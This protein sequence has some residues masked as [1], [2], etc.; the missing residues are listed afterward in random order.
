MGRSPHTVAGTVLTVPGLLLVPGFG[1]RGYRCG[2]AAGEEPRTDLINVMSKR[3]I[4]I[5]RDDIRRGQLA[6]ALSKEGAEVTG[7]DAGKDALK[8]LLFSSVNAV[9]LDYRSSYDPQNPVPAG[10][11]MVKE[12]TS[13]DAFV[14][15]I[16]I[17]DRCDTLSHE[18]S[19]AADLVLRRPMTTQQLVGGIQAVLGETLRERAQR[20]SGYIFAFR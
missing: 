16:L 2:V 4:L 17:C 3:I 13:V 14:P 5:D 20:K 1:K 7:F 9:V 12:I 15:L 10:K 6:N 18:T 11:R 19:A 8:H